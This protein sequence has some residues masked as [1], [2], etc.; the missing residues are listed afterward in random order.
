MPTI[1]LKTTIHAPIQQVFDLS[2]SIDFHLE[3]ATGSNETVVAGKKTGLIG[4]GE[5]VTW[6]ARH[7]GFYLTHEATITAFDSPKSLTDEMT[8]GKFNSFVH[9]HQFE[10]HGEN[11][12][13]T[14]TLEFEAPFGILGSLFSKLILKGYLKKFLLERNALIKLKAE[15]E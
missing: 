14:D 4:L 5:T 10:S 3:S 13:M 15:E 2:R 9:Q 12:I 1:N 6:R 11:T 8:K 7:F